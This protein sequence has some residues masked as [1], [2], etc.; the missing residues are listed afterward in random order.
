MKLGY[1]EDNTS[2]TI[3]RMVTGNRKQYKSNSLTFA[4][5]SAMKWNLKYSGHGGDTTDG[6]V[7]ETCDEYKE[8]FLKFG[9]KM[10]RR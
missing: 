8:S 9:I 5:N 10:Y 4:E 1:K 7:S 2:S 6:K 3:S